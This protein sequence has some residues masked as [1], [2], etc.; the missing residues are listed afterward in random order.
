MLTGALEPGEPL[1][2]GPLDVCLRRDVFTEGTV[3]RLYWAFD[4]A[5]LPSGEAL[6][7]CDGLPF[8]ESVDEATP[9]VFD[10]KTEMHASHV[11]RVKQ[12]QS[13]GGEEQGWYYPDRPERE[14]GTLTCL[15]FTSGVPL[16]N[17]L[18]V[19]LTCDAAQTITRDGALVDSK[20]ASCTVPERT[21]RVKD[22][23]SEC[24]LTTVPEGG[25]QDS[26]VYVETNSE[27]CD[28]GAC[29]VYHLVGDPSCEAGE[30]GVCSGGRVPL[31]QR[32]VSKRMYCS[33]RCDAPDGDPGDLCTCDPGFSCVPT[34]NDGAPGVRGS[35]CVKNGTF[36]AF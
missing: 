6:N 33:C 10:F 31:D 29:L 23:G 25:F 36:N 12:V 7:G 34:L 1:P 5:P 28:S 35:Y 26:T 27:S 22:I 21:K 20:S 13:N 17:P 32:E 9:G 16:V 15:N 3:C 30:R 4:D 19:W 18:S 14:G 11:C 2:S 24:E 8:L